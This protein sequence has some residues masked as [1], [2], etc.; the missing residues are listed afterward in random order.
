MTPPLHETPPSPEPSP[1]EPSEDLTER[2]RRECQPL[3]R[4]FLGGASAEWA[5]GGVILYARDEFCAMNL[6]TENFMLF[7]RT[8]CAGPAQVRVRELSVP[9]GADMG[10]EDQLDGLLQSAGSLITLED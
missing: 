10:A 5:S 2:I 4:T 9:G 8:L 7:L 3:Y 1:S 6:K